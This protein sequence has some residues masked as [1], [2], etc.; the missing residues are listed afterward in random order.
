MNIIWIKEP[1]KKEYSAS[2]EDAVRIV[3]SSNDPASIKGWEI[4]KEDWLP[5]E[6]ILFGKK[7][8]ENIPTNF[9]GSK[10]V[11][12]EEGETI[13][14]LK[15]Y[16][17]KKRSPKFKTMV[18]IGVGGSI[19]LLMALSTYILISHLNDTRGIKYHYPVVNVE[20]KTYLNGIKLS[21]K[22]S[23]ELFNY[24]SK[25]RDYVYSL[26]ELPTRPVRRWFYNNGWFAS[27]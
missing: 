26:W 27:F 24:E 17:D 2:R 23:D 1:Y 6:E 4:G 15:S 10:H 22:Q 25:V 9:L 11:P 7:P 12:K 3:N 18:W 21:D 20:R 5:L 16:P 19:I 14:A 8:K 13:Q